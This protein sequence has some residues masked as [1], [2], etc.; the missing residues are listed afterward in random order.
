M[1]NIMYFIKKLNF[2]HSTL[3]VLL[4]FAAC[5]PAT[6]KEQVELYWPPA[7][8]QPRVKYLESWQSEDDF[9]KG[10]F[11][12]ILEDLAGGESK[13]GFVKP[14]DVGSDS[15]G[16]RFYVTDTAQGSV[17]VVDKNSNSFWLIGA[18]GAVEQGKL[19]VPVGISIY[20][21]GDTIYV[22]DSSLDA[23]NIY[24]LRGGLKKVIGGGQFESPAGLAI[25]KISKTLYVVDSR[26]H[27]VHV[28][29]HDGKYL[30]S[31]GDRGAGD[32]LLNFPSYIAVDSKGEIYVVDAGNFRIQVFSP[33]GKYLRQFGGIGDTP[34]HFARPKGIA[35]DSE[36]HVYVVDAA[37][38]NIQ[39]FDREGKLLLFFGGGGAMPG[40]FSVPAGIAIDREDRIYVVDQINKRV[41]VFQYLGEKWKQRQAAQPAK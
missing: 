24:S 16:S 29:S 21:E 1:E 40:Q 10:S 35:I 9:G 17:V 19:K 37:Y 34:G 31:F 30:S 26:K 7:P 13:I 8:E 4:L 22:S 38:Q 14:Q 3:L 27:N 15:M 11:I 6:V 20:E 18:R 2:I 32:G 25:N 39:I 23:V 36:D 41:Q 5:A 12:S 28:Y 33:E